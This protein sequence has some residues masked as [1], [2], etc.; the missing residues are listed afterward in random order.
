MSHNANTPL[1]GKLVRTKDSER[2]AIHIAIISVTADCPLKPGTD[3]AVATRD[4]DF[5]AVVEGDKVG[6]VDPFLKKEVKKGERFY[7]L[8]YPNTVTS[9]KHSWEHPGI[10]EIQKPEDKTK[11]R[12]KKDLMEFAE[13][14]RISYQELLDI[15]YEAHTED[16]YNCGDREDLQ[17]AL[18]SRKNSL[19]ESWSIVTG[20]KSRFNDDGDADIYFGCAC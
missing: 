10:K 6:I 3:V 7:L 4:D 15:L 13:D 16:Y 20:I 9:L 5:F 12:A 1:L 14:N 17:D 2:D 18:N 11:E 19:F 8:L